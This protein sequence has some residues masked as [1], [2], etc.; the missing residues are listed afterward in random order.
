MASDVVPYLTNSMKRHSLP[1]RRT[2]AAAV[3]SLAF[4]SHAAWA[5]DPFVVQDIKVQGLQRVDAGT[6]FSS[7]PVRIGESYDDDKGAATI[8]SLYELGLF[9]D[10]QVQTQG[11]DVIVVVTERPTINTIDV[12]SAKQFDKN[13]VLAAL[14]ASG[15]A[16]GQPY[17]KA[18]EDQAI[19]DLKRMYLSR[20]YYNL[21]V[22]TTMTPME[23]N[24]VN[25]TLSVQE[26]PSARIDSINFVGNEAFSDSTLKGQMQLDTGNWMSWYTKSDRYASDR[27]N[28]D[29]EAVTRFYKN[30]G[31]LEF[32][33]DSTQVALTPDKTGINITMNVTEGP[34]YV[35][36]GVSLAGDYLQRE[37]E[38]QSLVKIKPGEAYKIDDV[39]ATV[40]TMENHF[41][42]YGYAFAKVNA[43]PQ[44]DR[45]RQQVALMLEAVPSDRA[46]V[47]NINISG[48]ARTR[49][50][51]IRRELRQYESSWYNS[52][53][54]QTSRARVDRLGY[55]TDVQVSTQPVAGTSDQADLN[56]NV[57]EAHTGSLQ[58]GLGYSTSDSVSFLVGVSQDNIFGSGQSLAFEASNSEYNRTFSLRSTDPY[59][60]R[61]GVSRSFGL[62]YS[63]IE[64]YEAQSG[65]Y[66]D[67]KMQYANANMNFGIPFTE[68]DTVYFGAGFEQY[69]VKQQNRA[70][71]KEY[72]DFQKEYGGNSAYGIPLTV[73]WS[74]D[75]RDSALAPSSGSYHRLFGAVS[76]AGDLKYALATYRYQYF[77]PISRKYTFALNTD[78]A[79]GKGFGGKSFPIFKNFYAGGLSSVRGFEQSSLGP[80]NTDLNGDTYSIGGS[81]KFNVNMEVVAPFPGAGTDKTLRMFGFMDVGNVYADDSSVYDQPQN[82][83]AKSLRASA[84]VGIRWISPMGPLSLAFGWP[85]KKYEGDKLEKVQ[86]QIGTQF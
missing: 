48:N 55:F 25:V 51:V 21:D 80:R 62:S 4:V 39:D 57:K 46:Y 28:Q 68:N 45:E 37:N 42:N 23:R 31:Y 58:L 15:F 1:F 75:H 70:L 86:F 66:Y 43:V 82:K 69:K 18:V 10:V 2:A 20:G 54:I 11:R 41:G 7:M 76:P 8:R 27:L 40:Q 32:K 53:K 61:N 52:D 64:P 72:Q 78:L 36:S 49:D 38:F 26:G 16:S 71:P 47:R 19:Q 5:V 83:D 35:V 12:S 85:L 29:V 6:V 22:E 33:V 65:N 84:G 3:A 24:Q 79:Y 56:V 44:V 50:E 73:G 74:R 17:S 77:Y 30:R 14:A 60:T 9:N 59:F 34:R 81:K 63:D 67:Y 13:T